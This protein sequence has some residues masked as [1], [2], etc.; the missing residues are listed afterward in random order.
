VVNFHDA[1]GQGVA[2]FTLLGGENASAARWIMVHRDLHLFA[3]H[4]AFLKK[5][6]KSLHAY[7]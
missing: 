2:K 1:D 3:S 6:A 5:L 7:W 4:H